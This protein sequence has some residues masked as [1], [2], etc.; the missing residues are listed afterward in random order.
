MLTEGKNEIYFGH[1]AIYAA[2]YDDAAVDRADGHGCHFS[3][4]FED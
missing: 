1:L 2:A 3:W 4:T